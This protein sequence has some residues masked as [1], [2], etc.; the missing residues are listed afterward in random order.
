MEIDDASGELSIFFRGRRRLFV[1]AFAGQG[2]V[3]GPMLHIALATLHHR[4]ADS[5]VPARA[6]SPRVAF[7]EMQLSIRRPQ[8]FAYAIEA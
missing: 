6:V 2:I 8:I 5:R 4:A 3:E 1:S 7:R